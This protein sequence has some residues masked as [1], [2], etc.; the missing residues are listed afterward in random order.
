MKHPVFSF[1]ALFIP[2]FIDFSHF[3]DQ[4]AYFLLFIALFDFAVT[5]LLFYSFNVFFSLRHASLPLHLPGLPFSLFLRAILRFSQ[6]STLFI[7]FLCFF[8]LLLPFF[9]SFSPFAAS[10]A[11][12]FLLF[13]PSLTAFAS[14]QP[15]FSFSQLIFI[16]F[17]IFCPFRRF[18]PSF[19]HFSVFPPFFS[20]LL[21][22]LFQARFFT[23]HTPQNVSRETSFFT[24]SG[25]QRSV[26]SDLLF[27][28][29]KVTLVFGLSNFQNNRILYPILDFSVF[30]T[31]F[32]YFRMFHV[33]FYL[34]FRSF[35]K[36]FNYIF[37]FSYKLNFYI[38]FSGFSKVFTK[39]VSRPL[40][41]GF[42]PI[43]K[44]FIP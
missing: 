12:F 35:I 14:F 40:F 10:L 11:C 23:F 33:F 28:F 21:M 7:L 19:R 20:F 32:L 18:L 38:R 37:I 13:R 26:R 27:L 6:F 29:P 2:F 43:W 24:I 44:D 16:F 8:H 17:S 4:A 39:R 15:F 31:F 9:S 3:S 41:H 22:S 30:F 34:C 42:L 25:L 1:S 36:L 5:F